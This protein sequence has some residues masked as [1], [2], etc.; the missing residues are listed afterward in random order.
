MSIREKLISLL[1]E[2]SYVFAWS[3]KDMFEIPEDIS[4][5]KLSVN[6]EKKPVRQKKRNHAP[7]RQKVIDEEVNKLLTA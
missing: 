4:V 1:R 5:H 3:P 7:K 2:F 6:K